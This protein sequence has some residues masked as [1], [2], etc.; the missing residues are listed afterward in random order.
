VIGLELGEDEV[1]ARTLEKALMRSP[2]PA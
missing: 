1:S 2:V